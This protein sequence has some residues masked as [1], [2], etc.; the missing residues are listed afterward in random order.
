MESRLLQNGGKFTRSRLMLHIL[1]CPLELPL[2]VLPLGLQGF[3]LIRYS[4]R[5][6]VMF[7]RPS[8]R[9]G[10]L[11]HSRLLQPRLR[12]RDVAHACFACNEPG[13]IYLKTLKK[14]AYSIQRWDILGVAHPRP[15]PAYAGSGGDDQ[16]GGAK[17]FRILGFEA[18]HMI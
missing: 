7:H 1:C 13:S 10:V 3:Q 8:L 14:V 4:H 12:G 17:D 9:H 2:K 18:S 11:T 6:A 15:F 16:A 5:I